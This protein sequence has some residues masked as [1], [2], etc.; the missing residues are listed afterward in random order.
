MDT[1]NQDRDLLEEMC[2]E[3]WE[4]LNQVNL[5]IEKRVEQEERGYYNV[6]IHNLGPRTFPKAFAQHA[7]VSNFI[8]FQNI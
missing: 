6:A 3:R 7:N 8:W 1:N 2:R 4:P 5:P